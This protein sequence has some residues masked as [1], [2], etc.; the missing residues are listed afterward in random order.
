MNVIPNIEDNSSIDTK[1]WDEFYSKTSDENNMERFCKS[2]KE[3][4]KIISYTC[5]FFFIS[6]LVGSFTYFSYA[7]TGEQKIKDN[8]RK[9][10]N[11][12]HQLDKNKKDQA[13]VTKE[14]QGVKNKI[15]K[16]EKEIKTLTK[17]VVDAHDKLVEASDKLQAEKEKLNKG[18]ENLGKRLRNIYKSGGVGFLDVILSSSSASDLFSNLEMVKY[19][20]KNDNQVVAQ[21]TKTYEAIKEEQKAVEQQ[22]VALKKKQDELAEKEKSLGKDYARLDDKAEAPI[23]AVPAKKALSDQLTES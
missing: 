17:D 23:R 5:L 4:K 11:A 7:V 18:N 8:N 19:I 15:N 13:N 1:R 12:Q 2:S 16:T 20:F 10:N 9:I 3:M 14:M 6:M 22:E 21:L